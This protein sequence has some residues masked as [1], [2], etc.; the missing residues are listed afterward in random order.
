MPLHALGEL[1]EKWVVLSR[2][3]S[4]L[5]LVRAAFDGQ[6]LGR[7]HFTHSVTPVT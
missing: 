3:N 1:E 2:T 5:T 7:L 4:L 6:Q